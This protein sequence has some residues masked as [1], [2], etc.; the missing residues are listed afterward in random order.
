VAIVASV[1]FSTE[2]TFSVIYIWVQCHQP[3]GWVSF[4][5]QP[6]IWTWKLKI[7]Q[8]QCGWEWCGYIQYMPYLASWRHRQCSMLK[9]VP[10]QSFVIHPNGSWWQSNKGKV[11]VVVS[12]YSA[13][14]DSESANFRRRFSSLYMAIKTILYFMSYS[15]VLECHQKSS[16]S[17]MYHR[18]SSL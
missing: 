4:L 2:Q 7:W 3:V 5:G 6:T 17:V 10:R 18:L 1:G 15:L 8:E 16:S 14:N 12:A 9:A 11:A 13:I